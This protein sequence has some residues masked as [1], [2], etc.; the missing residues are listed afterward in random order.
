MS[1]RPVDFGTDER[2]AGM[3]G[4]PVTSSAGA[5]A[6]LF[7]S[8]GLLHKVGP[9]RLHIELCRHLNRLGFTTLRFDLGGIGDSH[10][11]EADS[12]ENAALRDVGEA[13]DF[14]TAQ[15]GIQEFVLCG[16][17]SGAET[18][19]RMAVHDSRVKGLLALE[20]YIFPT[21]AYYLWHYLPR[22]CSWRKWGA[23][24]SR[25]LHRGAA[26]VKRK[27][28]AGAAGANLWGG[29][30]V[31]RRQ[32]S[33]ELQTLCDR[34]V[35]QLA[36]FA[37]GTGD[38]SYAAQYRHAFRRV[39]LRSCVQVNFLPDADHMY[40]LRRDRDRLISIIDAWLIRE[41][42]HKPE[43]CESAAPAR[44][45]TAVSM[46]QQGSSLVSRELP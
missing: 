4:R 19:H 27:P 39:E 32:I 34:G 18:A 11:A 14:V 21:A 45:R 26:A 22:V 41:F 23:Y 29:Q 5:P 33:N 7:L 43:A 12:V 10:A 13:M 31:T 20:G 8:A 28:P 17:C 24:L 37:G 3:L 38:C 36:V 46:I 44:Q 15:T 42:L 9:Y 40:I 1:E 2:L 6:I 16:L 30:R 25:L 35:Q